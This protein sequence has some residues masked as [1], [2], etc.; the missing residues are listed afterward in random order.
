MA[1][2]IECGGDGNHKPETRAHGNSFKQALDFRQGED[3][4]KCGAWRAWVFC[5]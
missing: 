3:A 5:S 1:P 4:W 2:E